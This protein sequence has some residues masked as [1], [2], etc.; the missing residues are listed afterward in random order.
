[1][2]EGRRSGLRA[3]AATALLVL[4]GLSATGTLAQG[5]ALV[6]M[7]TGDT[8]SG[9]AERYH[10]PVDAILER[11]RL[12]GT[13]VRAGDVVR[14]PL[15]DVHGGPAQRPSALP[16]DF[17][18]HT[19]RLGETLTQI[20]GQH[21]M[22]IEGLVGANPDLPS[23]DL[24]SPD[25]DLLVPPSP[26]LVVRIARPTDLLESI[27]RYGVA[28]EAVVRANGLGSP[29]D[30]RSDMLVFLPGVVPTEA[31]NRLRAVR[32]TER[33]FVWPV[34]GRLSSPFG[35]RNLGLGTA[36][37]HVGIDIAAPFDTPV[38]ASRAGTVTFA[39]TAG[40]YGKLIK[41]RHPDGS[42]TRYAHNG[43]LLVTPG[44]Y[45]EQGQSIAL[46][47]STGLS[48]GPHVHFE[49]REGGVPR[50][51]RTLLP[52]FRHRV[53]N[54]PAQRPPMPSPPSSYAGFACA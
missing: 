51:P 50:D 22:T 16:P 37:F 54:A 35:P 33:N 40:S 19:V 31:M 38:F 1:V 5:Y 7:Q 29:L 48:T 42:E 23:R 28:P 18:V 25:T 20:A 32:A 43:C 34:V 41:I 10:V 3:W 15:G 47:E 36:N 44:M 9:I 27:T 45:V 53:H 39:G 11:N 13:D 24:L 17:G 46:V 4:V 12:A 14:V 8:L 26:G 21:N 6:T 52:L 2:R 30:I 49:I